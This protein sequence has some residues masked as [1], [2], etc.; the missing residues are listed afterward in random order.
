LG[1]LLLLLLLLLLPPYP[2]SPKE[3]EGGVGGR[4]NP[5]L[6]LPPLENPLLPREKEDLSSSSSSRLRVGDEKPESSESKGS[7][8]GSLN[9]SVGVR[10]LELE[11]ELEPAGLSFL[12]HGNM[13]GC[14]GWQ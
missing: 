12:L 3:V 9:V 13:P 6:L 11:P 10:S 1:A 7:A 5:L 2:R 14:M 8:K 4:E